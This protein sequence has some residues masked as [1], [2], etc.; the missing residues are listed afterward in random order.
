MTSNVTLPGVTLQV[1]A[2]A[3]FDDR[4]RVLIAQRPPGKHMAG[5]WEFP[6]GKLG[7]D[8]TQLAALVRELQEE[9]GV[10]VEQAEPLIGYV[11]HYADRSVRLDLWWVKSYIGA[12]ESREGQ[13]LRWVTIDEL[14]NADLL[15]ADRPM[16][17]ALRELAPVARKAKDNR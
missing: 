1:V 17:A 4:H 16:I 15:E 14:P 10:T 5:G 12:P 11:H 3:L 2:G 9:I 6:G 8:E 13:A 7:R